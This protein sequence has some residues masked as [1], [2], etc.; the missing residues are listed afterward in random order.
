[1]ILRQRS[2]M[3][4]TV[5][6][7]VGGAVVN[8]VTI[9]VD[10]TNDSVAADGVTSL[11]E[12]ILIADS[13]VA[14][15]QIIFAIP[16]LDGTVKTIALSNELPPI[17]NGAVTIDGYT[18]SGAVSNTSPNNINAVLK[19]VLDGSGTPVASRGLV[20]DVSNCR[21]RGLVISHFR[22]DGIAIIN[23]HENNIIE[24]NFIG[25][26]VTGTL[27]N[28]NGGNGINV[29]GDDNVIGGVQVWQRNLI[30]G[31]NGSGIVVGINGAGNR[32]WGNFIGTDK[33]RNP[34]LG[35]RSQLGFGHGIVLDG[36]CNY[37]GIGH[38]TAGQVGR[39]N[40]VANNAE[41]GVFV[42]DFAPRND[43]RGN[44]IFANGIP[45]LG[46]LGI[47]LF[48]D[49]IMFPNDPEVTLN[50]TCDVDVDVDTNIAGGNN[51][52]NFPILTSVTS[53]ATFTTITGV[54]DG[55]ASTTNKL[56]FFAQRT[57]NVLGHGEG[58]I[59]FG[60]TNVLTGVNCTNSFTVT[61]PYAILDGWV[62]T[63]TA[64][65]QHVGFST[66]QHDT[67]EFSP[68][69]PVTG[70]TT[71]GLPIP[72]VTS[73]LV[74]GADIVINF[75]TALGQTYRVDFRDSLASGTNSTVANNIA[76]TG[77]I[78]SVTHIGGAA[79]STRF[80]SIAILQPSLSP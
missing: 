75:V 48:R 13:T 39:G 32:I 49:P 34:V 15:D 26:D 14:T 68:C 78:V 79:A 60:R 61:F 20:I 67:S 65:R 8:A 29:D 63:A 36:C 27:D 45:G 28:G 37:V 54:M 77:G 41:D 2:I 42:G 22:T 51:L 58:E 46:G 76:G 10:T 30:S 43:I 56:E 19:V 50:D 5:G 66:V 64:S 74:S 53:G 62:V 18:Q 9:T 38:P 70:L 52:Q 21:I 31:N 25:T 16:P 33:D 7:L 47:D 24:G 3:L 55:R 6:C 72:S 23:D 35:N 40:I 69:T 4:L 17:T 57:G 73:N 71:N 11:R 80:Y 1:M 59:L 12:A 44:S